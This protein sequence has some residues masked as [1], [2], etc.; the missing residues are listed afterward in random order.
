MLIALI[1]SQVRLMNFDR[2]MVL[3][4]KYTDIEKKFEFKFTRKIVFFSISN[5]SYLVNFVFRIKVDTSK[6]LEKI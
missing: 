4:L 3:E 5:S 1:K 6:C 2:I